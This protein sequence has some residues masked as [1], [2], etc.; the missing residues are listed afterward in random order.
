MFQNLYLKA[1]TN[2][3]CK[4]NFY[5]SI[6]NLIEFILLIVSHSDFAHGGFVKIRQMSFMQLYSLILYIFES[7]KDYRFLF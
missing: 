2:K 4:Y 3:I 7:G 5:G 6:K 1:F